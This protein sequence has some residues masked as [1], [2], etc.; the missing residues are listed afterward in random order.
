MPCNR[1]CLTGA[2]V[3]STNPTPYNNR[4]SAA[5]LVLGRWRKLGTVETLSAKHPSHKRLEAV[6]TRSHPTNNDLRP[7]KIN[8]DALLLFPVDR[9]T[10][11]FFCSLQSNVFDAASLFQT[12]HVVH[13]N[14]PREDIF[15]C[16]ASWLF[17]IT[18]CSITMY[19]SSGGKLTTL[20][21]VS[22]A[23]KQ[24]LRIC[25]DHILSSADKQ[26]S[27]WQFY[28]RQKAR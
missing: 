26:R 13:W 4:C 10:H 3:N 12:N 2:I 23:S 11:K 17:R 6:A 9:D 20:F 16:V 15:F 1:V 25:P 8:W 27:C 5:N 28:C 24:P 14:T 22:N 18:W 7:I 21:I 19:L